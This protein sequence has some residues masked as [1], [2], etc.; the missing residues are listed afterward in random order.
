MVISGRFRAF[1]N[2]R[3]SVFGR[4]KMQV[5]IERVRFLPI[6]VFAFSLMVSA[7]VAS[8]IPVVFGYTSGTPHTDGGIVAGITFTSFGTPNISALGF[9]DYG[10][11]GITGSYPVGLWDSTSPTP[12]LLASAVVTPSSPLI[13][14]FRWVGIS[15]LTLINGETYTLGAFL[16]PGSSD[17]WL[18][19]ASAILGAGFVNGAGQYQTG[20]GSLVYPSTSEA[21]YT[22]YILVNADDITVPEPASLSALLAGLFLIRRPKR[23]R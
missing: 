4:E 21:V 14:S 3:P 19:P 7:G 9:F 13:N 18:D 17:V 10:D 23:T 11:D 2:I 22:N 12:V 6:L 1:Q 20:A 8:A 16:P 5:K 15:P